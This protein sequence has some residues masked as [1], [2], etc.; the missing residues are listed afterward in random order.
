MISASSVR[1]LCGSLLSSS[2][3]CVKAQICFVV[4]STPFTRNVSK[5]WT[6][7]TFA[8]AITPTQ[9]ARTRCN[10][11][12]CRSRR[13]LRRAGDTRMLFAVGV[14]STATATAHPNGAAEVAALAGRRPMRRPPGEGTNSGCMT[15][16]VSSR[17]RRLRRLWCGTSSSPPPVPPLPV[18]PSDPPAASSSSSSMPSHTTQGAN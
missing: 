17:R 14:H 2:R 1:K 3:W 9:M 16:V 6:I 8:T 12:R 15:A 4:C 13:R 7:F 18:R 11:G 5:Q 10:A